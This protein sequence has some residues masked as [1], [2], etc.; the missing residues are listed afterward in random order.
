MF[1]RSY[2]RDDVVKSLNLL[3][4]LCLKRVELCES[5]SLLYE[6]CHLW[7]AIWVFFL[8]SKPLW[9]MLFVCLV[10]G[11]VEVRDNMT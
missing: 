3:H 2:V 7:G 8:L 6:V 4:S 1:S 10:G 11:V 5:V 9:Y